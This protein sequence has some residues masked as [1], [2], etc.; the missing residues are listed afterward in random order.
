MNCMSINIRGIGEDVKVEWVRKLRNIHKPNFVGIQETQLIDSMKIDVQ[1]YWGSQDYDHEAMDSNYRSGGVVSIWNS[2]CFQKKEVI[3]SRCFLIIIGN[4]IGIDG[5][6]IFA[7]IYGP[8]NLDEQR[9]IWKELINIKR[10]KP[11]NR[12]LF[13]TSM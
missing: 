10:L 6:T 7:N 9:K 2:K 3:K 12:L 5:D 8:H 13:V 1:G 11:R 4:W